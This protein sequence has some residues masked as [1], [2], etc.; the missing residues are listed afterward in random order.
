MV[1]AL[2]GRDR[3][4]HPLLGMA[5]LAGVGLVIFAVAAT[6]RLQKCERSDSLSRAG[7]AEDQ[8][9]ELVR[10]TENLIAV[11][12]SRPPSRRGA[13]GMPHSFCVSRVGNLAA[14]LG[15][16]ARAGSVALQIGLLAFGAW[17][18]TGSRLGIASMIAAV[19][20][21][22]A[23]HPF[24]QLIGQWPA[25]TAA[26]GAWL[27]QNKPSTSMIVAG[28][29]CAPP[30]AGLTSMVSA[31]RRPLVDPRPSRTSRWRSHRAIASWSL[32]RAVRQDHVGAA[33][34]RCAPAAERHSSPA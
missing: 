13:S 30:R 15:A 24:E 6:A 14:Q 8:A 25:V 3:L 4:L 18:V 16:L 9:N 17:L 32:A 21:G 22:R 11:G 33:A 34:A 7:I 10:N 29:M 19:L 1:A 2:P 31:I 27:R 12:M 26:R 5:A 28:T 20:L 23:L